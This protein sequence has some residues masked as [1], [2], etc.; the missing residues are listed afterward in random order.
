MSDKKF[1]LILQG[2]F[3]LLN[4]SDIK[5]ETFRTFRVHIQL[6]T[7]LPSA[8][9]ARVLVET[10][11]ALADKEAPLKGSQ[12]HSY[13]AISPSTENLK[14]EC[15]PKSLN[16]K[17]V[18]AKILIFTLRPLPTPLPTQQAKMAFMMS[19]YS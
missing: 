8:K 1:K 18:T 10:Q 19:T 17:L 15:F 4:L 14:L 12:P 13:G 7:Y 16:P 11:E 9:N 6:G 5:F 3:G 2:L